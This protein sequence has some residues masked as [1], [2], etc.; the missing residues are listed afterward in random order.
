[1]MG[2]IMALAWPTM[3]EQLMQTAVQYIDTAMVGSL[4]T[5][6]TAAVG[7]TSTVSWLIGSTVSAFGVGFLSYIAKA[8]GARDREAARRSVSQAVLMVLVTG[9]A[10]TAITLGLSRQVPVWMQV[11]EGIRDLAARY[12]FILYLPMLPRAASMIF[13]T[14]LRAAGDTKTPMRIGVIVNL[15]NVALNFLLIYPT[16]QMSLFG[17]TFTMPGADWGVIGAAVASA[18]S[19]IWGGVHI[20]VKLWKHPMVSPRGQSIRPD[21]TILRPCLRVA[22]PNMLQRFG[23]SLGYVAFAAMINSLGEVSTA[24]HTIANTVESA[25]YIPGYGMQTA[26]A[27]LAGNAYGAR[28]GKR[29]KAL[30]RMFIPIEIGLMILSGGALFIL[31]PG[32]VRI[33]S[34][35]QPVIDLGTTVLRMVALSEPFYGFSIIIEGMMQGVGKT[36]QPFIY[37]IL[38]MWAVRIVGTFICT[39]LL[40]LGLVS[41]WACMIAHN[42]LLFVLFLLTYLRGGWNPLRHAESH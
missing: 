15:I 20:T 36:R 18:V 17:L 42:L 25:F 28:D 7:A 19:F 12:F 31:A 41:A 9:V 22:L 40:G 33:F 38:G 21:W 10:F 34:S 32:L 26:A 16:R 23:T 30:A 4:G 39:Q 13:G 1:M 37:N 5:Q 27:T 2:V 11:E 8:C 6:A 35:S 24:A 14:V 3:L 29:M